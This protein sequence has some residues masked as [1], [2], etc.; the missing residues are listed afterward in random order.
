MLG[1]SCLST[2]KIKR[3]N[4]KRP[5]TLVVPVPP[6]RAS[7]P[8]VHHNRISRAI[9]LLPSKYHI[10]ASIDL[11]DQQK[12]ASSSKLPLCLAMATH[13]DSATSSELSE[14]EHHDDARQ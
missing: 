5:S 12:Q 14:A 11:P 6:L 13:E 2:I 8:T 10:N 4:C 9:L 3:M 1:S 7:L